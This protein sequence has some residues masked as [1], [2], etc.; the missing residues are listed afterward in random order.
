MALPISLITAIANMAGD[1][2]NNVGGFVRNKSLQ[3]GQ[4]NLN[5]YF[6]MAKGRD[7]NDLFNYQ[8]MA[9]HGNYFDL[10]GEMN[11][12]YDPN[13]Y[14]WN[15][16]P[17]GITMPQ[18]YRDS[19]TPINIDPIYQTS[20]GSNETSTQ[21]I[22]NG[23]DA[24]GGLVA[25]VRG[26]DQSAGSAIGHDYHNNV[27]DVVSSIP[28]MSTLGGAINRVGGVKT[29]QDELLRQQQESNYLANLA[30]KAAVATSFDDQS[31]NGP[32]GTNVHVN[33]YKAMNRSSAIAGSFFT[34]GP[35][36]AI[37]AS[38]TNRNAIK[39]ARKQNDMLT[40][41]LRNDYNFSQRSVDNAIGNMKNRQINN[42]LANY[43]AYGGPLDYDY[44][45]TEQN[46][47]K[48][49]FPTM[50]NNLFAF[51]GNADMRFINEGG[52]HEENPNGGVP[53]G[54]NSN[55]VPNLVEEGEVT[56]ENYVFS[57]RLQVP[58]E[59]CKTL[60]VKE[61]STF[62]DAAKHIS[63]E[64]EEREFDPISKNG[65]ESQ[66][67]DLMATQELVKQ[68]NT[69]AKDQKHFD[70]VMTEDGANM[71]AY[72][73]SI[74][75]LD[76]TTKRPLSPEIQQAYD[77]WGLSPNLSMRGISQE[78]IPELYDKWGLNYTP[79]LSVHETLD[80]EIPSKSKP[81]VVTERKAGDLP[82]LMRYAP[83]EGNAIGL[84]LSSLP[85]DYSNPK[86]LENQAK[87]A[88][89]FTPTSF[90]P[91][92]QKLAFEELPLDFIANQIQSQG[93]AT[94]NAIANNS[95]LNP[96]SA[97]AGLLANSYNTQ[98]AL[99]DAYLKAQE[100]NAE[101]KAKVADFNR[102]TDDINSKG[103]MAAAA[104]NQQAEASS[105][106]AA[107]GLYGEAV[108]LREQIDSAKAMA[109]SANLTQMFDNIGGIGRENLLFNM[110]NSDPSKY[111][112]I[113]PN[114]E[115][116]FKKGAYNSD[117][118]IKKEAIDEFLSKKNKQE[119]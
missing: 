32:T 111:Y 1:A 93:A 99:S 19:Y 105:K 39:K 96:I 41:Q 44:R 117:G 45:M 7:A 84:T 72:G 14:I 66:L 4:Q 88:S 109:K 18:S 98:R 115:I 13:K 62:S 76:V 89:R 77:R 31:L 107:A 2:F 60:H 23:G 63:K 20:L 83:V 106:A 61:G 110:V 112:T 40:A 16:E 95:N 75:S 36:A 26:L 30:N 57:D 22:S 48:N 59:M 87:I 54:V 114:G 91:V 79:D 119:K 92:S 27:G 11:I 116:L 53:L 55:G 82:T 33:P 100:I 97:N 49:L 67:K 15:P 25:A 3:R 29:R 28:L 74:N 69:A 70:E 12:P 21:K 108:K 46:I 101:R 73:G 8:I 47:V 78:G 56:F 38:I 71:F 24:I 37:G 104:A 86:I 65:K 64:S 34:A 5:N 9:N 80:S 94:A 51:G 17:N 85:A 43:N 42:L 81:V 103:F 68:L 118:T 52:S 50:Q 90:T 58:K 6:N 35:L 113:T 10:G 102:A